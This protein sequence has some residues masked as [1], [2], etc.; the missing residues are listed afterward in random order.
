MPSRNSLRVVGVT[1]KLI[2][3][4]SSFSRTT[5]RALS[6]AGIIISSSG[7]TAGTMAGRL[8]TSGL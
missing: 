1:Y 3:D 5:L 4:P 2:I 6:I 8:F 7:I